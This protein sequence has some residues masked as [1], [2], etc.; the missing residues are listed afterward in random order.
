[1]PQGQV[2]VEH[3]PL[4]SLVQTLQYEHDG[5][6][7][8]LIQSLMLEAA[9]EL[10]NACVATLE[11]EMKGDPNVEEYDFT[12][13]I[14][15]GLEVASVESIIVCGMC[16]GPY[17]KCDPCPNGWKLESPTCIRIKPC[18]PE[19]FTV[20]LVMRPTEMCNQLPDCFARHRRFLHHYVAGR[21]A[22]MENEKWASRSGARYHLRKADAL[23]NSTAVRERRGNH[24][25][26]MYNDRAGCAI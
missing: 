1:M 25:D 5:A 22:L 10:A 8:S 11:V 2:R 19:H 20:C 6:P 14:P 23:K 15:E 3:T 13:C 4:T 17:E 12:H 18:P 16:I 21:L 24:T 7:V 9:E 26:T